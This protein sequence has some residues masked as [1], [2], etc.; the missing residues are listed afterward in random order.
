MSF[1][2]DSE[3]LEFVSGGDSRQ[4]LSF[5]RVSVDHVEHQGAGGAEEGPQV[6]SFESDPCRYK[7]MSRD[8]RGIGLVKGTTVVVTNVKSIAESLGKTSQ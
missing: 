2:R 3:G 7:S 5:F 8:S 6:K 1:I 4:D